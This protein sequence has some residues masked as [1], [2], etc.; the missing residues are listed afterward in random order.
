MMKQLF[1]QILLFSLL[2]ACVQADTTFEKEAKALCNIYAPA[3]L[4]A[5]EGMDVLKKFE[6]VNSQTRNT[7]KSKAFQSIFEQLTKEAPADFFTALQKKISEQLGKQWTCDNAKAF[8]T[9]TWKRVDAQPEAQVIL[10]HIK[11]DKFYEINGTRYAL[12]EVDK[13]K[14]AIHSA[15]NGKDYTLHLQ[16]PPSTGRET[17]NKYLE[18]LRKIGVKKLSVVEK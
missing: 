5:A 7:I 15:A 14:Q 9:I 4:K 12:S 6:Y 10:V 16:I 3:N 2:T 13:I 8:Y 18:P 17:L 11:D 1:F